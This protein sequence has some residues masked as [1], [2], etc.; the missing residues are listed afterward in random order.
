MEKL[1]SAAEKLGIFLTSY[2]LELF[3]VYFNELIAWNKSINLTRITDYEEVQLKHFLD[4]LTLAE[5]MKNI[6]K[7]LKMADIG[8]GAGLPGIPLKIVF[9]DIDLTLIEATLKKTQFLEEVIAKLHLKDV[10][11]VAERAETVAHD[12]KYREKF[13]TVVSRAVASL[14]AL[15]ELMLPFCNIGGCCIV[16]KKGDINIEVEQSKKAITLMGGRIR[17]V[18]PIEIEEL[19]N[20]RWLVVIDKIESTPVNYPRRPGMPEKRP[21]IS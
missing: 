19:N 5:V 14:P 10:E 21:I 13:D 16:Q 15:A 1:K 18:K 20:N 11:I 4:S 12:I 3:K 6:K 7:S 8:T 17:E 9:S 2:Q